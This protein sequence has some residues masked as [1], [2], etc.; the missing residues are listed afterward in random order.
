[1]SKKTGAFQ[2]F[3]IAIL[4]IGKYPQLLIR[5]NIEIDCDSKFVVVCVYCECII[6]MKLEK[7]LKKRYLHR[8]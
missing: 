5:E 1:M 2:L 3:P 6:V 7:A 8:Y 4:L